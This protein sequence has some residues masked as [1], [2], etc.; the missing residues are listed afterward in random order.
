MQQAQILAL[1]NTVSTK[2]LYVIELGH[3]IEL[4]AVIKRTFLLLEEGLFEKSVSSLIGEIY[5]WKIKRSNH[6]ILNIFFFFLD[7]LMKYCHIYL[8]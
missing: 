6:D 5:T 1:T 4:L 3:I 2:R 7:L 8:C